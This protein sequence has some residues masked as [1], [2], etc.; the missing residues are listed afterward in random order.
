MHFC[1]QINAA[2]LSIWMSILVN[3]SA[4]KW[5]GLFIYV[6][7]SWQNSKSFWWTLDTVL[8]ENSYQTLFIHMC[9]KSRLL[10]SVMTNRI[11][12]QK[13]K[14]RAMENG[15]ISDFPI[16][17]SIDSGFPT[18]MFDY[19]RV[20]WNRLHFWQIWPGFLPRP[21]QAILKSILVELPHSKYI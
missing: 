7:A 3:R 14:H 11:T 10:K 4:Q 21:G 15:F 2:G 20:P 13:K 8:P 1:A 5:S 18:A 17:T 9:P 12:L 19:R 16:E 6:Q